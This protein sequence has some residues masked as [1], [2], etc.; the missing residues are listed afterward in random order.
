MAASSPK[1]R[2]RSRRVRP[3][4]RCTETPQR[5]S[6]LS[7]N[8]VK[9]RVASHSQ[10]QSLLAAAKSRN[11]CSL[12]RSAASI[13]SVSAPPPNVRQEAEL[14]LR[15]ERPGS[16]DR[17]AKKSR[18]PNCWWRLSS[19]VPQESRGRQRS[20]S[21][22]YY[23]HGGLLVSDSHHRLIWRRSTAPGRRRDPSA[24]LPYSPVR[25][26]VV[27][28]ARYRAKK[29]RSALRVDQKE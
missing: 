4:N 1:P 17:R 28:R 20:T 24:D 8:H 9:R 16:A 5:V 23:N 26:A 15:L 10:N 11:R 13:R 12:K 7:E 22:L 18:Q 21:Q 25:S 2:P 29:W 14:L 3:I 19:Y 6:A 27:D